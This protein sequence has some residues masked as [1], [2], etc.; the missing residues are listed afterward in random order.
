MKFIENNTDVW[1]KYESNHFYFVE[2]GSGRGSE[3]NMKECNVNCFDFFF[4]SVF[5]MDVMGAK[6]RINSKE[7][8]QN[9]KRRNRCTPEKS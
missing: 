8:H 4:I 7:P 6:I 9:R 5:M 3:D 1:K 2:E